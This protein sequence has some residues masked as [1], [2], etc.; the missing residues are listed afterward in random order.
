MKRV[1][2]YESVCLRHLVCPQPSARAAHAVVGL[3]SPAEWVP[4]EGEV[5]A[6]LCALLN[7]AF[8][9]SLNPHMQLP[10]AH[11]FMLSPTANPEQVS[12]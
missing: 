3:C 2:I 1:V 12:L 11:V 4:P 9:Q 8:R 6:W 10:L 5:Q 7:T